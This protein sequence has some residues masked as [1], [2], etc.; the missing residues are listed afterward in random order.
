MSSRF[1]LVLAVLCL[2]VL[3]GCGGKDSGKEKPKSSK[4]LSP[5]YAAVL[6]APF[7]RL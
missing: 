6:A 3:P 4:A 7:A 5:A 1:W 2:I